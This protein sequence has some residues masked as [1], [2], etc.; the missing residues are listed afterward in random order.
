[1]EGS[2][3]IGSTVVLFDQGVVAGVVERD[4]K[5]D[6]P[7]VPES[8]M[9]PTSVDDRDDILGL[10]FYITTP[11]YSITS[12]ATSERLCDFETSLPL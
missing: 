2:I 11:K 10:V 3:G 8:P 4:I 7:E 6:V 9:P 12:L 1:M 5:V